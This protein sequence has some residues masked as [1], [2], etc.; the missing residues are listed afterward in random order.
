MNKDEKNIKQRIV[1]LDLKGAPPKI[2]YL[3]RIIPLIRQWGATGILVEYEDMFPYKDELSH[4]SREQCYSVEDIR[5]IQDVVRTEGM[6]FIPLVQT[7][8]HL[9]YVLKHNAHAYL[10]EVKDNPMSLCPSNEDSLPL[11]KA[12][13]EQVMSEHEGLNY[14][15]IGG[16]EVR[17]SEDSSTELAWYKDR[18]VLSLWGR[19]RSCYA[20]CL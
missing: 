13:I 16:D 6:E 7:F 20:T 12:L 8:G 2:Q 19:N 10:R 5:A 9:E 4:I 14:I 3:L 17:K 1:H 15:H 18:L 11:I